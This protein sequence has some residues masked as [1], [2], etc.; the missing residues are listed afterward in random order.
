MLESSPTCRRDEPDHRGVFLGRDDEFSEETDYSVW[1][2]ET[3]HCSI[4]ATDK[5]GNLKGLFERVFDTLNQMRQQLQEKSL[6]FAYDKHFGYLTC[7]PLSSGTGITI[8]VEVSLPKLSHHLQFKHILKNL[9]LQSEVVNEST[10]L[11]SN[12]HR[13]GLSEADVFTMFAAAVTELLRIEKRF[14]EGKKFL[15]PKRIIVP[16]NEKATDLR[17]RLSKFVEKRENLGPAPLSLLVTGREGMNN[18]INGIYVKCAE[19]FNARPAYEKVSTRRTVYLR[20]HAAGYWIFDDE[21]RNDLEGFAFSKTDAVYPL[22]SD[23]KWH[24]YCRAT[25]AEDA[26]IKIVPHGKGNRFI[27]FD[28]QIRGCRKRIMD[29]PHKS[30]INFP[31]LRSLSMAATFRMIR[32]RS[33]EHYAECAPYTIVVNGENPC[34]FFINGTYSK[35]ESLHE[36]RAYW[37]KSD[38]GYSAF[39]RWH[40]KGLWIISDFLSTKLKGFALVHDYRAKDPT[41]VQRTWK[42]MSKGKYVKNPKITV[43]D[44]IATEI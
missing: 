21:L 6:D 42:V 7:D 12:Q 38:D 4:I 1:L 24:V 41:K 35:A 31:E 29:Y 14:K 11:I 27:A 16:W 23:I 17:M 18:I 26:E 20:W 32:S 8:S 15:L 2:N 22:G 9:R 43:I 30:Q 40:P 19:H 3:E 10:I 5:K 34:S 25:F 28:E 44:A 36:G 13:H 37:R 33:E 39:M